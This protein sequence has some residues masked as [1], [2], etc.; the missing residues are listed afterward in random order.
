MINLF[1]V[2]PDPYAWTGGAASSGGAPALVW[3]SPTQTFGAVLFVPLVLVL[4]DLVRRPAGAHGRWVLVVV[5]MLAEVGAKATFLPLTLAGVT[6]VL[7][8]H[9]IVRREVHRAAAVLTGL[10][11]ATTAFAQIVVFQGEDKGLRFAPFHLMRWH[12]ARLGP[13]A[14]LLLPGQELLVVAIFAVSWAAIWGGA[15]GLLR[16]GRWRSD[17]GVLLLAGLGAAGIGAACVFG[18]PGLSQGYFLVSAAPY[19]AILAAAGLSASLPRR[20]WPVVLP[21][22]AVGAVAVWAVRSWIATT[23][24]HGVDVA[25]ERAIPYAVL[26]GVAALLALGLTL[27][28]RRGLTWSVVPLFALGCGLYSGV[29][30]R[31]SPLWSD[32]DPADPEQ[33]QIPYGGLAAGRWLREHSSPGDLVAANAHCRAPAGG[34]DNRHFWISAYA[35]RRILVEG[36]GYINGANSRAALDGSPG[37]ATVPFLDPRR[38]ADN[39]AAFRDPTPETLGTL[40]DTYGVRWLFAD[41]RYPVRT[42]PLARFATLRFRSGHCRVYEL[43]QG[44]GHGETKIGPPGTGSGRVDRES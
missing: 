21:A 11:L 33:A 43:R 7:V 2:A 15:A 6:L 9:L 3:L 25:I 44:L 34:C 18:H 38:L 19:L 13:D 32:P 40:R 35:E 17:P 41:D 37:M 36:W 1:V 16:Q 42:A 29:P 10:C 27:A 4:I 8:L 20:P 31:L 14:G 24:P 23:R 28:G 12:E 30:Q 39:D 26:A 22:L 5:L